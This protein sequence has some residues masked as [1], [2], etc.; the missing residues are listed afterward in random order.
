MLNLNDCSPT[1]LDCDFIGN[2]ADFGAG[3]DNFS[4]CHPIVT[5]CRF[6]G[7]QGGASGFG[8]GM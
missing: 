8:V 1:F 3:M 4:N 6:V 7:N 2:V 5:N